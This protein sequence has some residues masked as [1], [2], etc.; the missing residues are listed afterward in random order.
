MGAAENEYRAT[1]SELRVKL[2]FPIAPSRNS[3]FRIEIEEYLAVSPLV[4]PCAHEQRG[5]AIETAVAQK[6]RTHG[7]GLLPASG[8]EARQPMLRHQSDTVYQSRANQE[9]IS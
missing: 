1:R 7:Y 3:L 8:L 6:D 5:V 2:L 9:D 4:E